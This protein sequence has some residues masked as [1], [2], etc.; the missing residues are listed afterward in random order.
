MGK[1]LH[2]KLPTGLSSEVLHSALAWTLESRPNKNQPVPGKLVR[3]VRAG[4]SALRR[5][6]SVDTTLASVRE[7]VCNSLFSWTRHTFPHVVTTWLDPAL[8]HR[9]V[10]RR[11]GT[12]L[13]HAQFEKTYL[14]PSKLSD[15]LTGRPLPDPGPDQQALLVAI[16]AFTLL[17]PSIRTEVIATLDAAGLSATSWFQ[18]TDNTAEETRTDAP[19]GQTPLSPEDSTCYESI[20]PPLRPDLPCTPDRLDA[21]RQILHQLAEHQTQLEAAIR[22]FG[23][24]NDYRLRTN[25]I[26]DVSIQF[27]KTLL[28]SLAPYQ[29]CPSSCPHY[30]RTCSPFRAPVDST[31]LQSHHMNVLSSILRKLIAEHARKSD[32]VLQLDS[33]LVKLSQLTPSD[34]AKKSIVSGE[35]TDVPCN[36][37]DLEAYATRQTA[38]HAGLVQAV[39]S[40][41]A[42]E[43]ETLRA[44][45]SI[46]PGIASDLESLDARLRNDGDTA[47]FL[48]QIAEELESSRQ[49]L[50]VEA[51]SLVEICETADSVDVPSPTQLAEVALHPDAP[52]E[53][54]T[55]LLGVLPYGT[56]D[57]TESTRDLF[58]D[59]YVELLARR[60]RASD[61]LVIASFL[62]TV[63][64]CYWPP[65][66]RI[67]PLGAAL[68]TLSGGRIQ[69]DRNV[70]RHAAS[71]LQSAS[72]ANTAKLATLLSEG[73]RPTLVTE[74]SR[75]TAER[76]AGNLRRQVEAMFSQLLSKAN[77][78]ADVVRCV[79]NLTTLFVAATRLKGGTPPTTLAELRDAMEEICA[80]LK[81]PFFKGQLRTVADKWLSEYEQRVLHTLSR[82]EPEV[83]VLEIARECQNLGLSSTIDLPDVVDPI[84]SREDELRFRARIARALPNWY[85]QWSSDTSSF[86]RDSARIALEDFCKF[87]TPEKLDDV[88][89]LLFDQCHLDVLLLVPQVPDTWLSQVDSAKRALRE[90]FL[91]LQADARSHPELNEAVSAAERYLENNQWRPLQEALREIERHVESQRASQ[92]ASDLTRLRSRRHAIRELSDTL[93]ERGHDLSWK[94]EFLEL[95]R[96]LEAQVMSALDGSVGSEHRREVLQRTE[97]AVQV[98]SAALAQSGSDLRGLAF[99]TRPAAPAEDLPRSTPDPELDDLPELQRDLR[100]DVWNFYTRALQ[101]GDEASSAVANFYPH[102]FRLLGMHYGM[103]GGVARVD[104]IRPIAF[105]GSSRGTGI[106]SERLVGTSRFIKPGSAYFDR[107]VRVHLVTGEDSLERVLDALAEEEAPRRTFELIFTDASH[108]GRLQRLALQDPDVVDISRDELLRLVRAPYPGA[109]VRQRLR[110]SIGVSQTH[111]FKS[112]GYIPSSSITYVKRSRTFRQ[113]VSGRSF[114]L[115][116]GRRSGK[117]S[118]LHHATE[119]RLAEGALARYVS[120]EHL[121]GARSVA[122][123]ERGAVLTLARAL[124]V[125]AETVEQFHAKLESILR[126]K[127]SIALYIDEID[128]YIRAH[129]EQQS[130]HFALMR[131]L[132]SLSNTFHSQMSCVTAGFKDLFKALRDKAAPTDSS[133]PWQ[134]W[135]EAAEPLL[136]LE[137]KDVQSMLYAGFTEVLGLEMTPDV[138]NL[139]YVYSGG[140][141]AAV[142]KLA[143]MV[144]E[145]VDAA[146]KRDPRRRVTADDVDRVFERT[147]GSTFVKFVGDT[148]D[149]NFGP[150]ERI[151]MYVIAAEMIGQH[152]P[153]DQWF[154][155]EDVRRR[156]GGWFYLVDAREPARSAFDEAFAFL[157]MTG[158]MELEPNRTRMR[159]AKYAEVLSRLEETEKDKI[160]Q[161]IEEYNERGLR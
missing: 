54:S 106:A 57:A 118:I 157:S 53:L 2:S 22:E 60:V 8:E 24:T 38:L 56:G 117:T 68:V 16:F 79:N 102:A 32:R 119:H 67:A 69:Y 21:L 150:L 80:P 55:V 114:S 146:V 160:K 66:T 18:A 27:R 6:L 70:L 76:H 123:A 137:V 91:Q 133:Y 96:T 72:A 99:L 82:D 65:P 130:Q 19:N 153:G 97:R 83:S 75:T 61:R 136:A 58:W 42:K 14:S 40:E 131:C 5:H 152:Y 103:R 115:A 20:Q 98:A 1:L 63:V 9:E 113:L 156:V 7:I 147:R 93:A 143:S 101:E 59:T 64:E 89:N 125:E 155:T 95:L 140:S 52:V 124:E 145:E 158:M 78:N 148:L 49:A 37:H 92:Y 3:A 139:A 149:M 132:R 122:E 41:L 73:T 47:L 126:S 104:R 25:T 94:S 43:I 62:H 31:H 90:K 100:R 23:H 28:E 46:T 154:E 11:R 39:R 120:M 29:S 84:L 4:P 48:A 35:A 74:T 116:G 17:Q 51:V 159:Y 127:K 50:P 12:R 109:I 135:L 15:L 88:L 108:S 26:L 151:I 34:P 128:P 81:H 44:H 85:I 142:Q 77:R 45:R 161:L 121:A 36:L 141:P 87:S 134:N 86:S 138:P 13:A 105:G 71:L 33:E 144:L 10:K 111:P 112:E 110:R 107:D 30:E 129:F